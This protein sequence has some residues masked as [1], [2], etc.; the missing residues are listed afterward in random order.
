MDRLSPQQTVFDI[1]EL[2]HK[3]LTYVV[4]YK[5]ENE[6]RSM[7]VDMLDGM[8]TQHW[9]FYCSCELCNNKAR[10]YFMGI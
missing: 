1:P 3:I 4:K 5:F 9:F 8:I 7:I 6:M 2:K 10:D